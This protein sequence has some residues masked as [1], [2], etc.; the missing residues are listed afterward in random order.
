MSA[1]LRWTA[2]DGAEMVLD[3]DAATAEG[4]ESSADVT[5]HPVETG[6]A[7]ADH[8]H[9]SNDVIS[10]E[11]IIT[12]APVRVPLG[13][14]R[15]LTRS[16]ANAEVIV[17]GQPVRVQLQRWS[18]ALDRVRECDAL[19]AALVASGTRVSLTS[20]LRTIE[21]L[22]VVRYRVDRTAETGL[23]LP[24]TLDLKRVRVVSTSR[25]PV[26]A[27]PAARVAQ[28][29]GAVPPVEQ[30]SALYNATRLQFPRLFGSG[31]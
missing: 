2:D 24:L 10:L 17:G 6:S 18:G 22:I 27:V 21:N 23:A 11:G 14:T 13:Q 1:L 16:T 31:S 3:I 7:I 9:P 19:F 5:E 29:R 8:V 15:G 25:A 4:F 20:S 30:G 26:P 12:S 28:N